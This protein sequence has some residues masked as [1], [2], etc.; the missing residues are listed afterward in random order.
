[1]SEKPSR[2]DSG[3]DGS[4]HMRFEAKPKSRMGDM[5]RNAFGEQH[6]KDETAQEFDRL[7][8]LIN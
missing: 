3:R 6:K 1:M 4:R 2:S 5:L 7:L 8:G